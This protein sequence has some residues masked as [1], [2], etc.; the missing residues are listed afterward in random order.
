VFNIKTA[1]RNPQVNRGEV[2]MTL[3]KTG[4]TKRLMIMQIAVFILIASVSQSCKHR[5]SPSDIVNWNIT[6]MRAIIATK[7]GRNR[8]IGNDCETIVMSDLLSRWMD[9]HIPKSCVAP[10]I[11]P[12]SDCCIIGDITLVT[13]I[14]LDGWSAPYVM[15]VQDDD[16]FDAN[17]P[18]IAFTSPFAGCS[19]EG[20]GV[21][22]QVL[23]LSGRSVLA[24]NLLLVVDPMN[25]I[26]S[27][28]P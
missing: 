18:V 20:C 17:D 2:A 6:S 25:A 26:S 7:G 12:A 11:L 19:E 23:Y 22:R 3:N 1:S 21:L 5:A 15:W 27:S 13:R 8:W 14:S 28:N 9:V 4:F 10:M 16:L 24:A